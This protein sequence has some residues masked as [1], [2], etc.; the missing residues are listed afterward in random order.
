MSEARRRTVAGENIV[1]VLC[2]TAQGS[3]I[4]SRFLERR[5]HP[6]SFQELIVIVGF[7]EVSKRFPYSRGCIEEKAPAA[8]SV[9]G[10][11]MSCLRILRE[12]AP[13]SRTKKKQSVTV[14]RDAVV[15]GV[16][17]LIFLPHAVPAI[18]KL[19]NDLFQKLPVCANGQSAHVLEHEIRGLQLHD[20]ADKVVNKGIAWVVQSS[21]SDRR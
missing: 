17:N 12:G 20:D 4:V 19:L 8:I 1:V 6:I 10:R 14:L 16:Q 2:F 7:R 5:F 3:A 9:C 21:L 15:R 13:L 11:L 18:A